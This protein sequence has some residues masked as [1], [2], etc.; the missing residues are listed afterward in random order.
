M[1]GADLTA[2]IAREAMSIIRRVK[3]K[4]ELMRV[5]R[6]EENER[7]RSAEHVKIEVA[8]SAVIIKAVATATA[9]VA[10]E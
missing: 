3:G 5:R 10:V 8:E 6:M 2:N 9:S 7:L 4:L 1:V